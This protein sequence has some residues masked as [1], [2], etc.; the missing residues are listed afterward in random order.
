[1]PALLRY[2][3]RN[4]MAF[5][6]ESRLPFLDYRLVNFC[7]KLPLN[8]KIR[9]G[10]SKA[11]MRDSLL[12]PVKIRKRKDKLGF[13]TPEDR[14]IRENKEE[15]KKMFQENVR[16]ERFINADAVLKDWDEIIE[17]GKIPYFFR[18]ICL[19]RWMQLFNVN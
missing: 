15:F 13:V 10:Y 2:T 9:N 12:M 8:K 19:E 16:T 11:I 4:S 1:M 5:S 18:I 3:D 7:A 14:W 6:V 17:K